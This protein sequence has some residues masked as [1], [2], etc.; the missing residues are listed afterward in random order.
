MNRF[1]S[2]KDQNDQ[3]PIHM[4]SNTF[5]QRKCFIFVTICEL[6]PISVIISSVWDPGNVV[7]RCERLGL[8]SEQVKWYVSSHV[9]GWSV[10]FD[11]RVYAKD[12]AQNNSATKSTSQSNFFYVNYRW[13]KRLKTHPLWKIAHAPTPC[14]SPKIDYFQ[15]FLTTKPMTKINFTYFKMC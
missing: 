2:N 5:H 9:T 8:S 11:L 3:R 14:I 10:L 1:T 6:V 12:H 7:I 4:S 13:R 15:Y